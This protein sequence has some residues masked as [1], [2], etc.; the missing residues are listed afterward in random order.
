MHRSNIQ[1]KFTKEIME[2][3]NKETPSSEVFIFSHS[4]KLLLKKEFHLGKGKKAR[5]NKAQKGLG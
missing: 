5:D 4:I 3:Y 1:N 2:L